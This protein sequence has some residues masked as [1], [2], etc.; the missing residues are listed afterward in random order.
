M[1][2][3]PLF[4]KERF[5]ARMR[6]LT[7]GFK[8]TAE[9]AKFLEIPEQTLR[10]ALAGKN[11][12]RAPFLV[13]VSEKL[14]VPLNDLLGITEQASPARKIVPP[15]MVPVQ[16]L[17]AL[18]AAGAGATN[19]AVA[20]DEELLFP[21]WMIRTL[22]PPAAKLRFMRAK[23]ES[24]VPTIGDGALLLVNEA[25]RALPAKP[26]RPKN[27][28]DNP[29]VYV[30]LQEG[31]LRVKRL[32]KTPK[33]EIVVSSDNR[34]YDPEVLRGPDLKRFKICGRVVWWDNRL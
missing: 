13:A 34:A 22:A 8:S 12:P 10:N 3:D 4:D 18:A 9:A 29:D 20:V 19:S 1:A 14:E 21:T 28:F 33:G 30:F 16:K 27:E 15:Q 32:R 31:E 26:P 5:G 6:E 11:E 24:M 17:D 25:E 2:R 7:K 23:G